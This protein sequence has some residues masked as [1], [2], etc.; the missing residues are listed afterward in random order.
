MPSIKHEKVKAIA[1]ARC[2]EEIAGI[3]DKQYT[4]QYT[5]LHNKKSMRLEIYRKERTGM[6]ALRYIK[7]IELDANLQENLFLIWKDIV[8][9]GMTVAQN[10]TCFA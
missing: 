7:T 6:Y 1:A 10:L 5:R 4:L 9:N 8:V 3:L 2:F